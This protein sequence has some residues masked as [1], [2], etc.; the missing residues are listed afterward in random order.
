MEIKYQLLSGVLYVYFNG[1]LDEYTAQKSKAVL[2][3]IIDENM[4]V[5]KVI[6]NLS[7]LSFMDSTGIG[8]LIGRYKRLSGVG[9]KS[10]LEQPLPNVQ[11]VIEIS[12]LTGLM[13]E[14]C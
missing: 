6:F 11:K 3:K 2:D 1:E 5:S 4:N 8:L 12:G 13:P 9:I 10:Y 14:I 7:K